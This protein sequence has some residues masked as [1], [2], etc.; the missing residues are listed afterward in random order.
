MQSL[1]QR[2]LILTFFSL[3]LGFSVNQIYSEGIRWPLLKPQFQDSNHL[4]AIQFASADS[5]FLLQMDG[6]VVF[7]D[8]RPQTE[9]EIDRIPGA[10]SIPLFSYYKSPEL[11][12]NLNKQDRYIL[13]CFDPE[14]EE[15][16]SLAREMIEKQ[17]QNVIV[18]ETGFSGW[19]EMGFPVETP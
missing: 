12:E 13:Y 6:E 2:L 15:A 11:L 16:K 5:A 1:G 4:S 14:C 10:I 17:F 7:V 3:A 8:V 19:L 18:L 9:F